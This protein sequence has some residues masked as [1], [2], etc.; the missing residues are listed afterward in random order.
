LKIKLDLDEIKS[1]KAAEDPYMLVV[2]K[3]KLNLT[4]RDKSALSLECNEP[5][6]Q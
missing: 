5:G 6:V 2:K 1:W 3:W 4:L